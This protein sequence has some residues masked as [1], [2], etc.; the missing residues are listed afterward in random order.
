MASGRAAPGAS[1]RPHRSEEH[2]TPRR[3]GPERRDRWRRRAMEST[4]APA[5][6]NGQRPIR[7]GNT[8]RVTV[9]TQHR[10][11]PPQAPALAAADVDRVRDAVATA[12]AGFLDEQR[13]TLAGMD[14]SLVP[15]VDEI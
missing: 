2:R 12:L 14:A 11:S 7:L 4:A 3:R 6:L 10:Q 1:S 8:G 9:G 15:V 13:Q 5:R